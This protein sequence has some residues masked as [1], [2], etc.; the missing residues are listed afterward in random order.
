MELPEDAEPSKPKAKAKPVEKTSLRV[1]CNN[2][3]VGSGFIDPDRQ[4]RIP[5]THDIEISGPIRPGSWLDCQV[6]AGLIDILE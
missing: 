3:V 2:K 1:K 6:K 5:K 4:V